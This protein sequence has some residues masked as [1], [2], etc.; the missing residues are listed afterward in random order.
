VVYFHSREGSSALNWSRIA[1]IEDISA[2]ADARSLSISPDE[3]MLIIGRQNR[4]AGL[5]DIRSGT[6]LNKTVQLPFPVT[7]V[8]F[9]PD[10][11]IV[12]LNSENSVE[13]WRVSPWEKMSTLKQSSCDGWVNRMFFSS[14]GKVLT[15]GINSHSTSNTGI[16][17]WNV[18]TGQRI[19]E[20]NIGR[21]IRDIAFSTDGK[22]AALGLSS[23]VEIWSLETG[24]RVVALQ[25]DLGKYVWNVQIAPNNDTI[26]ATAGTPKRVVLWDTRTGKQITNF[27]VDV[28]CQP[29]RIAFSPNG[30]LLGV[31]CENGTVA[32]WDTQAQRLVSKVY[33]VGSSYVE[34]LAF[35]SNGD[36][37]AVGWGSG[38]VI[39]W[40][41]RR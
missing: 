3:T 39:I 32:L 21:A 15:A 41:G 4:T 37:L 25:G 9:S 6:P 2:L 16:F 34:S 17:S 8:A 5:W 19:N 27:D 20:Q 26:A 28:E 22:I 30:K 13:I 23:S 33:P 18:E 10:N 31:G 14:N 38:K 1:E 7:S 40:E 24:Q 12:A 11:S 35:S 29:Y 36:L